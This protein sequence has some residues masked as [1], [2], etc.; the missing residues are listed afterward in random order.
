M[1][2]YT[3]ICLNKNKQDMD[4]NVED[5]DQIHEQ[6]L[7]TEPRGIIA[8]EGEEVSFELFWDAYF[9]MADR[10]ELPEVIN[11][12]FVATKVDPANEFPD[13]PDTLTYYLT[14]T[15]DELT[16][17]ER[18]EVLNYRL[19]SFDD[20]EEVQLTAMFLQGEFVKLVSYFKGGIEYLTVTGH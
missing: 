20:D 10:D 3:Y 12:R 16:E 11:G 9:G 6:I 1:I 2:Y 8:S 15:P 13:A 14:K 5:F 7:I 4:I 18:Y 19:N 17:D